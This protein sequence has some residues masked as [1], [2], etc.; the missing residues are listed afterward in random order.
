MFKIE[1]LKVKDFGNFELS[2][3]IYVTVRAQTSQC[4]CAVLLEPLWLAD[5]EKGCR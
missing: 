1:V 3:M 2:P 5:L 4:I